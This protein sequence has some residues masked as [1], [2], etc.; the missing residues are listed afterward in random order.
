MKKILVSAVII[1]LSIQISYSVTFK[2]PVPE[3]SKFR[4]ESHQNLDPIK[5]DWRAISDYGDWGQLQCQGVLGSECYTW[6]WCTWWN[7][8]EISEPDVDYGPDYTTYGYFD[9]LPVLDATGVYI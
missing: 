5:G 9:S 6:D 2:P 7:R 1:L 8:I 3:G 4:V